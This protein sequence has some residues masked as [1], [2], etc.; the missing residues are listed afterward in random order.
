MCS[1]SSSS[2]FLRGFKVENILNSFRFCEFESLKRV[3][4]TQ[5]TSVTDNRT[6]ESFCVE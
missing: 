2:V 5:T 3:F 6:E 4:N 1:S